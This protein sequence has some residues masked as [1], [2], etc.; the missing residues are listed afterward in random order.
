MFFLIGL[1]AYMDRSNISV[2]AEPMMKDFHMSKVQF[3]ALASLFSLGYALA[4]IPGGILS[5][6]FG[7]RKIISIA[8]TWWSIFTALTAIVPSYGVLGVVRFLFGVGEGPM[9]PAS[10]V[11]N[12]YWFQSHEKGRAASGLLAG[13]YFG[14]VIA[15]AISVAIFQALGWHGV[16]YIF[17]ILGLII[18]GIWYAVARDKPENHP[19]ISKDECSLILENRSVGQERRQQLAPWRLFINRVQFWAIGLQYFIVAYMTTLF[20]TWLP[21]YLQE[22]RHFSLSGMGIAASFPWLAIFVV[23]VAGGTLSDYL[24][25]IG[26]S[27]LLARGGL[28]MVGLAL[29]MISLVC[30]TSTSVQWLNVFWLTIALGSLGLPVVTSWAVAADLGREYSGSVSGWMNLWGNI[31]GVLSPLVCGWFAQHVGWDRAL[32]VNIVPIVFA[33]LLWFLI[34]PDKKLI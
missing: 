13:S 16:F 10:A 30:A 28:A 2:V 34:K 24:I 4:Q 20:L 9:Y 32:L 18:A 27:R 6:I 3:G 8:M 7:P 15:P 25:R 31:G 23:V 11:F 21:T 14:P 26:I 22:A 19:W 12:S 1:I 5:E 29:F 33:I 17:G